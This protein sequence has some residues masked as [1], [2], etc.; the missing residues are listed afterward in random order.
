MEINRPAI[1]ADARQAMLQ[2]KPNVFWFTLLYIVVSY[3][4]STLS[5]R[6][7]GTD[8][9]AFME[10]IESAEEPTGYAMQYAEMS[11][12]RMLL[13]LAIDLMSITVSAG[14]LFYCLCASRRIACG[15][16]T[17]LDGF[18]IFFRLIAL[19]L[20]MGVFIILWS[21]LLIV[22]GII[23]AYRY[24]LAI[25]LLFD[26]PEYSPLECIRISKK[27]MQ[28]RKMELFMLD[29]ST[30]GWRLLGLIPLTNLYISPYLNITY[31]NYYNA[32][33]SMHS[34]IPLPAW[35]SEPPSEE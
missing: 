3:I 5:M 32:V 35:I 9:G 10:L 27:L 23:A 11:P 26:H 22:P 21:L 16:G 20:L 31:C 29:L 2:A 6:L 25:Y 19:E 34:E 8:S 24:R 7:T 4:L 12:L 33:R 13:F 18:S 14:F 30:I 15:Y 1:K 17:L 28:G